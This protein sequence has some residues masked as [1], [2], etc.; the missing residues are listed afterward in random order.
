MTHVE[1]NRLSHL[2]PAAGVGADQHDPLRQL[3]EGDGCAG[4][5][6]LQQSNAA[7]RRSRQDRASAGP[8][9]L[10]R[11]ALVIKAHVAAHDRELE[12][13]AG[14]A[15]A[16]QAFDELGHD[17]RPLRVSEVEAIGHGERL[18][19]NG[20]KVAIR[21]RDRLLAALVR[22]GIAVPRR[23]VGRHR[24][25]LVRPVYAHHRRVAARAL[26]G[27]AADLLVVLL[28]DPAP[29]GDVRRTHQLH[30][31][32]ADVGALR[33]PVER[34]HARPFPVFVQAHVWPVVERRVVG[35][36]TQRNVGRHFA[37]P[38]QHHVAGVGDFA[39]HREIQLPLAKDRLGLGLAAGLEDDQHPLLAFGQHHFVGR[40]AVFAARHLVHVE[41]NTGAALRGHL[42]G[43]GS[44][45]R[46]PHVLNSDDRV[47]RHQLQAR[48]DQQLFGER[49]ADLHR[50][51]LLVA[52]L[53]EVGARHGR[54][55]DPV[56]AGLGS[57]IDDRIADAGRGRIEDLVGAGDADRHRIDQDVAVIGGVEIDL[58][59]D[60]GHADA[61]AVAADPCDHARHQMPRLG[62][63]RPS[64]PQR[65][66]VGDGPRAHGED[67]AQDSSDPCRGALIGFDVGRVV[68][69]LHL[70]DCRVA[71]ADVDDAGI[72]ARAAN[73][74]RRFGWQLL[75]MQ[76]RALVAAVLRP[77]DGED[78]ELDE[79]RLAAHRVQDALVFVGA[80][81]VVGNDLGR[82]HGGSL[83][84]AGPQA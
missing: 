55:V 29:A 67:V 83:T 19:P 54:A 49:I 17:L 30:E 37:V 3:L 64:E 69:A 40:H 57:D 32:A 13:P 33:H 43:R 68:V 2:R 24:Q 51:A 42:D 46:R 16:A 23:Y 45:A 38:F 78:A 52:V 80:E 6:V 73:H 15:H 7:D 75:E 25:R 39:D 60:R 56:A 44:E 71:V 47:G 74:P 1:P 4:F 41:P 63:V 53:V 12:R 76:A 84:A 48:F 34:L 35:E 79:V 9:V 22:V 36:R 11:L 82:D 61:I 20:A 70:E 62:M 81:A 72:L 10:W 27:V 59:A 14:V 26:H 21:L 58:A 28:V 65:I 31:V 5:P 50:R 8:R 77:H 18:R 66:Q